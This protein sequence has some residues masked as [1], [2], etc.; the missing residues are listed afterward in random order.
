MRRLVLGD[1]HGA[2]KA[3]KQVFE[4]ANFDYNQDQLIII[5]DIVDGWPESKQCIDELLK[6]KNFIFILGNHDVWAW[7]WMED[8]LMPKTWLTQGGKETI[9]SYGLSWYG[10]LIKPDV[11][12]EHVQ[13]FKRGY[14][15]Y[16]TDDNKLFVHGGYELD[17]PLD[18]QGWKK[19]T[20]DRSLY[21]KAQEQHEK[22]GVNSKLT[23]YDEV[24]IGH[25]TT[26]KISL[27]PVK[28]C[29]VW[30]V[31]QGAGWGGKL[32][33]MDV[34]TKEIWSSDKVKTLYEEVK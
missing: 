16:L 26:E 6:V 3:L 30:N 21:E 18:E 32:T 13:F 12:I 15:Y 8:G 9:K 7:D 33:L 34:D 1:V 31:D 25:T 20:W 10:E 29:E 28:F 14:P 24:F 17:K 27:E 19:L 23:P 4:R 5:G 2:Y 22:L 11:P